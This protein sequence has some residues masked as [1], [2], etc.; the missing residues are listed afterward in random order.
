[1]NYNISIHQT[2]CKNKAK[3]FKHISN[4]KV[5]FITFF[6]WPRGTLENIFNVNIKLSYKWGGK[7]RSKHSQIIC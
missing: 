3:P 2:T 6:I 5:K 1:M 4:Q 7:V